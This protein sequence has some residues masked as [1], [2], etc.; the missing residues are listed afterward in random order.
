MHYRL[1]YEL[2]TKSNRHYFQSLGANAKRPSQAVLFGE[3]HLRQEGF[4][5]SEINSVEVEHVQEEDIP[6][7]VLE[8]A[9]RNVNKEGIYWTAGRIEAEEED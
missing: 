7:H 4:E 2:I 5:D 6:S 3:E 1:L 9:F 8:R